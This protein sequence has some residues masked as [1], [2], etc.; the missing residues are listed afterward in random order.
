MLMYFKRCLMSCHPLLAILSLISALWTSPAIAQDVDLPC[1]ENSLVFGMSTALTGPTA[2]LGLG[3]R[4]GVLAAFKEANDA[5]GIQGRGL[6]LLAL[7]DGYEPSRTVPNIKILLEEQQVLGLIGN[8]GTPTAVAAVPMVNRYKIPFFGAFTGAGIL[9]KTPPDRYVINY[10]AS[11]VEETGAMI[12]ALITKGGLRPEEIAC[13]TQRDAYGDAGYTGAIEALKRHGL[14]DENRITHGRYERNTL[15]VENGLADILLAKPFP[16][17]VIMVGTSAPCAEFIKLAK[18]SGL[19]AL[20]LNVSFVDSAALAERLG[21]LGEGVLVTQVVP[22]YE[23]AMPAVHD[24]Q[25]ALLT[26]DPAT[27]PS[28][29]SL[30][31]YLAGRILAQ[32]LRT[33]PDGQPNGEKIIDALEGLGTFDAGLDEPLR[34]DSNEHQASHRVWP[35]VIRNGRVVPFSWDELIKTKF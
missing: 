34:L 11:Y 7:D 2:H 9:R 27:P 13:F 17:A 19:A 32:A 12:D 16:R 4:A 33:I 14:K 6:C 15:A 31:G 26:L 1:P 10:R 22:H 28:M 35:T 8:V 25:K 24:F 21:P 5:G 23:S 20:F 18:Q 29:V 30:E 3:M